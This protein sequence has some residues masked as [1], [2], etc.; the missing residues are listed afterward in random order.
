MDHLPLILVV[1][2]ITFS[3]RYFF[4]AHRSIRVGRF[5]DVFAVALFVAIGVQGLIDPGRGATRPNVAAFVGA[6]IGGVVFR[7]S[8]LGVVLSGFAVYWAARLLVR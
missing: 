7:R 3:S 8:M 6:V 5:L 2:A 1:A 4:F